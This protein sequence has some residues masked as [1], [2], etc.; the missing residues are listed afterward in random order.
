MVV[1]GLVVVGCVVWLAWLGTTIAGNL[2]STQGATKVAV[3]PQKK[4]PKGGQEKTKDGG[5]P[6][7]W[8]SES[9]SSP[10]QVPQAFSQP[11]NIMVVVKTSTANEKY[12]R[13]EG[14]V[15]GILK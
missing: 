12:T 9:A 6:P 11:S 15:A 13:R 2:E 8:Q 1:A 14:R 7:R 10:A 5:T 4:N 3:K